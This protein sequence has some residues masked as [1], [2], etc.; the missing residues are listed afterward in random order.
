MMGSVKKEYSRTP[1]ES[2]G[3]V[4]FCFQELSEVVS[5]LSRFANS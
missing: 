1:I 4:I 5:S 3:T 2:W